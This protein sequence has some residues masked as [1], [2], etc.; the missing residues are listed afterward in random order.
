MWVRSALQPIVANNGGNYYE[1]DYDK[2]N[3]FTCFASNCLHLRLFRHIGCNCCRKRWYNME[4]LYH[5]VLC[6]LASYCGVLCG[7]MV[8]GEGQIRSLLWYHRSV[9]FR[10]CSG[11]FTSD[12]I[13]L[14]C[15]GKPRIY[16]TVAHNFSPESDYVF[17][18]TLKIAES[19][20]LLQKNRPHRSNDHANR[21]GG[22]TG[23]A[24]L[25]RGKQ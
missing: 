21:P 5:F 7:I 2:K 18:Q 10:S 12:F 11:D 17:A 1:N 9:H 8:L 19:S 14:P 3:Q 15:L 23:R 6:C 20:A 24:A 4:C 13:I 25:W 16:C 22:V